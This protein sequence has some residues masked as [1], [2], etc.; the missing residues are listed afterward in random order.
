[1][2]SAC[3]KSSFSITVRV[4]AAFICES[5]RSSSFSRVELP[6]PARK[7]S[8]SASSPCARH[9]SSSPATPRT[10]ATAVRSRP[11][12]TAAPSPLRIAPPR[13]AA[14]DGPASAP[15]SRPSSSSCFRC[16]TRFPGGFL[17]DRSVNLGSGNRVGRSVRRLGALRARRPG[18]GA[19][20]PRLDAF[21]RGRALD[22]R[23]VPDHDPRPRDSPRLAHVPGL[24]AE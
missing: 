23:R 1:M 5:S 6:L 8:S 4:S 18:G 15:T 7:A 21:R 10:S 19:N 14:R 2:S 3:C 9:D 22:H 17:D 16:S 11:S 12:P 24:R 13:Y 20:C